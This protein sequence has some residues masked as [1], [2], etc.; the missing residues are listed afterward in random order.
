LIQLKQNKRLTTSYLFHLECQ[1]DE[2]FGKPF[3]LFAPNGQPPRQNL[4]TRHAI[5]PKCIRLIIFCFLLTCHLL[6]YSQERGI[7]LTKN[8]K[9]KFLTESTRIKVKL[10]DGRKIKGR[11]TIINDSV[12]K[13]RGYEVDF[14]Q[15]ILIKRKPISLQ[16]IGT[17]LIIVPPID[18]LAMDIMLSPVYGG[19]F[20]IGTIT[21]TPFV[22][23][24]ILMNTLGKQHKKA[25]GWN[26]QIVE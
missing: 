21:A 2:E 19:F 3:Q 6:I 13:I 24:G 12:I 26:Y 14:Q 17:I 7:K 15:I 5:Q 4:Y 9:E 11:F 23:A 1:V 18:G 25:K 8:Q 10:T 22:T 20:P 16:T